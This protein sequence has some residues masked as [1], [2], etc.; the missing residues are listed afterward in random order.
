MSENHDFE[1]SLVPQE[2]RRSFWA[3]FVVMLGFTFFSASMWTGASMGSG[4]TLKG[5]V[6]AMLAGNLILGIYTSVL[7]YIAA[8]TG[9]S[10][11]LLARRSF[12][13]RGSA[14]PSF[15]LAFTQIGWFGVG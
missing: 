4:L 1:Q 10:V 8:S 14:L 3:M 12:G 9:L 15:L 7:A 2:Q 5:F 6:L 11:H 13:H